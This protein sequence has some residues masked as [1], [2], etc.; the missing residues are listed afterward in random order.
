[1]NR[2][3]AILVAQLLVTFPDE[4]EEIFPPGF[5]GMMEDI[6]EEGE[7]ASN[8]ASDVEMDERTPEGI[9]PMV[10]PMVDVGPDDIGP[11][12]DDMDGWTDE[13]LGYSGDPWEDPYR[14]FTPWYGD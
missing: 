3:T 13:P 5:S 6:W 11:L 10:G 4:L 9:P 14:T 8:A 2:L 7:A 1:M 12:P